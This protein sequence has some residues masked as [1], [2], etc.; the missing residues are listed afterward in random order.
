[1]PA[2]TDAMSS[3]PDVASARGTSWRVTRDGNVVAFVSVTQDVGG[4]VVNAGPTPALAKPYRFDSPS[5][6]DSFVA[7]IVA[8]FSYLGCEVTEG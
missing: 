6:A 4:V 8:S 1:M 7:D 5:Q 3:A 2:D